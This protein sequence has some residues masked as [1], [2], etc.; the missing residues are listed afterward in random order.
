MALSDSARRVSKN[1]YLISRT[2]I[3]LIDPF[4]LDPSKIGNIFINLAEAAWLYY[5]DYYD[6]ADLAVGRAHRC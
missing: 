5:K 1:I 4:L 2:E 3:Y 6:R